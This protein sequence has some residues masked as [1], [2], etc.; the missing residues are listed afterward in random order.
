MIIA[1]SSYT[2]IL[3]FPQWKTEKEV[4]NKKHK[5]HNIQIWIMQLTYKICFYIIDNKQNISVH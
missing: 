1:N 5:N 3:T 2:P 4:N